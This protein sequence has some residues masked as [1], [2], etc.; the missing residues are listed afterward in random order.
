MTYIEFIE[1]CR[2]KSLPND[3][4]VHHIEPRSIGGVNIEENRIALSK[5]EHYIAHKLLAMEHPYNLKLWQAWWQVFITHQEYQSADDRNLI[6]E[7]LEKLPF[8]HSEESRRNRSIATKRYMDS[9][10]EEQ[11]KVRADKISKSNKEVY[12]N[13]ESRKRVSEGI[14]AKWKE[15]EFRARQLEIR[16]SHPRTPHTEEY[17]QR[18]SKMQTGKKWFTN[19]IINVFTYSCPEGYVSG[20]TRRKSK[21]V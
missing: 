4:E 14:K 10:T 18:M 15:P 6:L 12:K 13:S 21:N 7:K 20:M 2:N 8:A 16:R 9:L 3:F 17:K 5:S 1:S 19:G 11:K